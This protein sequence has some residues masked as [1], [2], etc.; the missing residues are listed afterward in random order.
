MALV[1]KAGNM[2]VSA[3]AENLI[4]SEIIKLAAEVNEK[5]RN[6]EKIYNLTIGDFNPKIFPI[7]AELKAEI[8]KAYEEDETNYPPAD[9]I[10][11]LRQSVSAFLKNEEG[12]DYGPDQILIAGGARPL[13][14]AIFQAVVDPGDTI[15]FPVPS[16]NNNHYTHLS[17][18][19]QVFVE[20]RPENNF[21]PTAEELA[22]HLKGATLLALCSPLNPTGTAFTKEGL[23][24]ICD[25]VI[26]E[27][28]RRGADEKP[29]YLM[30]D[31]IY[32]SLT[33]GDTTHV[34]PVTLRPELKDYTIFVDG[35]SKSLAATGIRVG[36]G[37]G[38][39][40]VVEKMKSILGH[41]GAWAPK[42][43]QIASARYMA[44]PEVMNAFL[45]EFKKSIFAR[46]QGFYKG[47]SDLKSEGYS[48]DA[49][50]PQSAIYL[51]VKVDLK[52]KT[53]AQGEKLNSA[54]DVTR[55]IL[56]E[57]K[58]AM[59]PFYAFGS[60]EDSPW[61]RISV[62]TCK[63]EEVESI[64]DSLRSALKQLK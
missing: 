26:S 41:V 30:Y 37:F 45:T 57:A 5:I 58:I 1:E 20:T 9:G 3:M 42:A 52:G 16:W 39:K 17:R 49:I 54:K 53:T 36:W 56:D 25:L 32:W 64:I 61:Y 38:P 24:Q 4:G 14:Y 43:E 44:K 22:P 12:L 40:K 33:Y 2:K 31:Q 34:N 21:M 23:E 11:Q 6:G 10:L 19:K 7:P 29:L 35:L 50:A 60:S 8:I 51:T 46:L 13:I 28:L 48:V 27:N 18:S 63:L 15:V 62:G 47:F 55:Y 59:V